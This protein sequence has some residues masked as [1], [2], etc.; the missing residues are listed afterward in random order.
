MAPVGL[1]VLMEREDDPKKCTAARLVRSGEA[2]EWRNPSRLPRR[3]VVLDPEA[4]KALSREDLTAAI[5]HGLLVLDCS[6]KR[7]ERFPR[8]R[9]GLSHRALPLLIAVNPTNYGKPQRLSSAEAF[10]AALYILGEKEHAER[11]LSGFKW[12][13]A[14]F[15]V[16]GERLEEYSTATDSTGVVAAQSRLLAE[17]QGS[18]RAAERDKKGLD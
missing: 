15:Q 12:G 6:W 2:I 7:L 11:L 13:P 14:F 18:V 10:A 5:K 17:A 1:F 16:N 9:A 8:I 4:E 3:M